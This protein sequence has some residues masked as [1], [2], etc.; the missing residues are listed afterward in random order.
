MSPCCQKTKSSKSR[1]LCL[2][3]VERLEAITTQVDSGNSTSSF[4]VPFPRLMKITKTPRT[5]DG[6]KEIHPTSL[7]QRQTLCESNTYM[8]KGQKET[9]KLAKELEI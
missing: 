8:S 4:I 6:P 1:I 7:V 5:M 2:H 9:N 3:F